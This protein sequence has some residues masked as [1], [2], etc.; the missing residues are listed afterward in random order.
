ME[1]LSH[2]TTYRLA[3]IADCTTEHNEQG[4]SGAQ[5]QA[6]IGVAK[7]LTPHRKGDMIWMRASFKAGAHSCRLR[8]WGQLCGDVPWQELL[9]FGGERGTRILDLGV[10]RAIS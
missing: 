3:P 2:S 5:T 4:P 10:M 7:G 6:G 1:S 9:D 8:V